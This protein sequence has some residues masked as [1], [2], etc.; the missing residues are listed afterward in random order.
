MHNVTKEIILIKKINSFNV[1]RN[2]K[3][4]HCQGLNQPRD[5]I[6]TQEF[7]APNPAAYPP[8]TQLPNLQQT[9]WPT[10]RQE[11]EQL[12]SPPPYQT[13]RY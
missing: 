12:P 3:Q 9:S 6:V 2:N 4:V 5:N 10:G 11:A 1:R 13:E 8:G 7:L